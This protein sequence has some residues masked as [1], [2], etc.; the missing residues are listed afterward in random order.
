V[1]H[2]VVRSDSAFSGFLS[3]T[4][5]TVGELASRGTVDVPTARSRSPIL[6]LSAL[7][8]LWCP[9]CIQTFC[10]RRLTAKSPDREGPAS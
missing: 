6:S 9:K 10:L 2:D 5:T 8:G 4:L 3:R 7:K 1:R